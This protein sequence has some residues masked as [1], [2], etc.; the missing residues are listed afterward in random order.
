MEFNGTIIIT[1]P[2]YIANDNTWGTEFNYNDYTISLPEFTNYL[3]TSTNVGDGRWKVS[4]MNNIVIELTLEDFVEKIED[5]YYNF[6]EHATFENEAILENLI[7]SRK[8]IGKFCVDSG[9]YGVFYLDEVLKHNPKF[10]TEYGDWCYTIIPDFIGSVNIYEDSRNNSH[11]LGTGNK[12]FYSNS[13]S[14][15]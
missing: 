2:C 1:D 8:T 13:V 3:W 12:T 7:Q 14:W 15:L 9:S 5:A 4:E 11:V 10:L 6:F